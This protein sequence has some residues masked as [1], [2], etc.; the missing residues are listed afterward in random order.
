LGYNVARKMREVLS[1]AAKDDVVRARISK[2]IKEE[3][4][5]VLAAMG[6]TPSEAYRLMMTRIARER[7]L[8]FEP[9]IPNEETIEAMKAARRGDLVSVGSVDELLEDLDADD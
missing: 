5:A 6:L 3:A 7:A 9:L 4:T 1:M 2:E 8:P